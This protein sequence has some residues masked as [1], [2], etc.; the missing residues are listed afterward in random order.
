ML[1]KAAVAIPRGKH[2]A[3]FQ[4][5]DLRLRQADIPALLLRDVVPVD[6]PAAEFPIF[7]Y[8]Y[9]LLDALVK[10]FGLLALNR[11]RFGSTS[12]PPDTIR[13]ILTLTPYTPP[14]NIFPSYGPPVSSLGEVKY[15]GS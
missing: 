5:F 9:E 10:Y 15:L 14:R 7:S 3:G 13:V 8:K 4:G 6:Y 11:I 12:K 2:R 1:A